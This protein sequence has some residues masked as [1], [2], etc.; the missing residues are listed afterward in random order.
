[1]SDP[2][3]YCAAPSELLCDFVI[4]FEDPDC[5][6]LYSSFDHEIFRCDAPLCSKH[7]R[8]EG[9]VFFPASMGG[10]DTIDHCHTHPRADLFRAV[11]RD[12]ADRQRR[13]HRSF[14]EGTR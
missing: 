6:G 2:C 8:N 1:M 13:S 7:A 4:G 12:E 3:I 9:R 5:D 11:K 14:Y 10:M